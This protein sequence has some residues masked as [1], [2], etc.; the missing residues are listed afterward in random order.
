MSSLAFVIMCG[1][2]EEN[3]NSYRNLLKSID[4]L[5]IPPNLQKLYVMPMKIDPESRYI[6]KNRQKYDQYKNFEVYPITEYKTSNAIEPR[7]YNYAL[8]FILRRPIDYVVFLHARDLITNNKLLVYYMWLFNSSHN[9]DKIGAVTFKEMLFKKVNPPK[10][11]KMW[12]AD[13]V[14]MR[15][16]C[17][18]TSTI[19]ETGPVDEYLQYKLFELDFMNR[20]VFHTLSMI[21][22]GKETNKFIKFTTKNINKATDR[23]ESIK[24]PIFIWF[25]HKWNKRGAYSDG[26]V[27][28]IQGESFYGEK[29]NKTIEDFIS[30]FEDTAYRQKLLVTRYA[31][32]QEDEPTKCAITVSKAFNKKN[33]PVYLDKQGFYDTKCDTQVYNKK[34]IKYVDLLWDANPKR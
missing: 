29:D 22:I 6:E 31:A 32:L 3:R 33:I 23:L 9:P 26:A 4:E 15:G 13:D 18:K 17:I 25:A 7:L 8:D 16:A 21:R 27:C 24:K 20:I 28:R 11:I 12:Y 10:N 30:L 34:E 19:R 5:N 2:G 14:F 1:K